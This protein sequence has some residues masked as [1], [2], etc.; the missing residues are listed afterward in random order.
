MLSR[1]FPLTQLFDF[2][3]N[4]TA[5]NDTAQYEFCKE[6]TQLLI[7]GKMTGNSYLKNLMTVFT[8]LKTALSE[9]DSLNLHIDISHIDEA[10]ASRLEALLMDIRSMTGAH[11]D[12]NL[13]WNT[14][15][16]ISMLLLATGMEQKLDFQ[17]FS[18]GKFAVAS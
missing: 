16:D 2:Y 12:V 5:E 1:L 14:G 13:F 3:N 9:I 11:K 15:D 6:T 10:G 17:L 7:T 4:P 18:A 8:A